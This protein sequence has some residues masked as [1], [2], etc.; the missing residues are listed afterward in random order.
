MKTMYG[1]KQKYN[2]G[3]CVEYYSAHNY[4]GAYCNEQIGYITCVQYSYSSEGME[5]H[6]VIS[7]GLANYCGGHLVRQEAIIRKLKKPKRK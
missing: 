2:I 5:L 1:I 7:S 3:D 6:Y 4:K